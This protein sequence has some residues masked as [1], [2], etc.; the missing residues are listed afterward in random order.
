MSENEVQSVILAAGSFCGLGAGGAKEREMD[1]CV[2]DTP[3]LAEPQLN[4]TCTWSGLPSVTR[5]FLPFPDSV[6]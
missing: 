1:S 6:F 4:S 2:S 5:S 3:G